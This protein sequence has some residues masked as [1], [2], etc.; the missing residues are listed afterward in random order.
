[1][2]L[3]QKAL[4][5][6]HM[7]TSSFRQGEDRKQHPLAEEEARARA[8]MAFKADGILLDQATSF[9][10][11]GLNLIAVDKDWPAVVGNL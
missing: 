6:Q 8:D 5:G 10:Y 2:V 1:M 4:T 3:S 7:M 9:K 11:L